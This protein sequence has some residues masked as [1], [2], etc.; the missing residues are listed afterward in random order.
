[1]TDFQWMPTSS[2]APFG[3]IPPANFGADFD[4]KSKSLNM[5]PNNLNGWQLLWKTAIGLIVGVLIAVLLFVVLSFI[6]TMFTDAIQWGTWFT[7]NPLLWIIVLFIG[8]LSAFIGNMIVA[9]AYS[10]FFSKKY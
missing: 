7:G 3:Q 8:F 1:M 6:G 5:E 2:Q 9:W 4:K 10:V